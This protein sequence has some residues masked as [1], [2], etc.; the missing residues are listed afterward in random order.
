MMGIVY[1]NSCLL[2][3]DA[4]VRGVFGF[5]VKRVTRRKLVKRRRKQMDAIFMEARLWAFSMLL[6]LE[7]MT[8][9]PGL[10]EAVKEVDSNLLGSK[11]DERKLQSEPHLMSIVF[12]TD[13]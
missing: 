13:D 4:R 10:H 2:V 5:M 6:P 1:Q 12:D 7:L 9:S 8:N 11:I 3:P